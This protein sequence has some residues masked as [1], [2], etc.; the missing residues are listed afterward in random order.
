MTSAIRIPAKLDRHFI[1]YYDFSK[2]RFWNKHLD[3]HRICRINSRNGISFLK[4]FPF[5]TIHSNNYAIHITYDLSI[6]WFQFIKR[7]LNRFKL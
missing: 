6:C 4:L 7:A 5:F 3:L 1:T 2:A